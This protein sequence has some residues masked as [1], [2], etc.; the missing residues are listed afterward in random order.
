MYAGEKFMPRDD[1]NTEAAYLPA[2]AI[3][4]NLLGWAATTPNVALEFGL[5]RKWTLDFSA[6]YNPWSFGGDSVARLW[7]VRP[8]VRYWPYRRFKSHF[9]S[10]YGVCGRFN[11]GDIR[12]PLTDA[13]TDH[14]FKGYGAG[15]GV[16]YGYHLPVARQWSLEFHI[17]VGYVYLRYDKYRC[18]SCD[19]FE[20]NRTRHY[21]G[22]TTAGVTLAFFIR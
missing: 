15:A 8:E 18:Y 13:F 19:E 14:R 11:I 5:A 1:I 12:I 16:S 10:L 7:M 2:A 22:P 20:G 4:S 9:L 21:F 17:G 3:K 6:Y